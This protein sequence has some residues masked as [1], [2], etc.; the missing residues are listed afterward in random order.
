[1]VGIFY[2]W[3]NAFIRHQ[4]L[5][6][7]PHSRRVSQ[8]ACP[9]CAPFPPIGSGPC[10]RVSAPECTLLE[11]RGHLT[12][13]RHSIGCPLANHILSSGNLGLDSWCWVHDLRDHV[14][15]EVNSFGPL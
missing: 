7:F 2:A 12:E 4:V 11:Q 5:P 13:E 10:G 15:V 14:P 3:L 1:M 6:V 9:V 8:C